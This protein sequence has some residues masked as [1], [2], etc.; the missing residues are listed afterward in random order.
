MF[1]SE[2]EKLVDAFQTVLA[3]EFKF[4]SVNQ[5]VQSGGE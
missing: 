1:T 4:D 3:K 5:F 2:V